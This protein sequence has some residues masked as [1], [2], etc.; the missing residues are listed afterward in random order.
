MSVYTV[1]SILAVFL[2]AAGL[3]AALAMLIST[4]RTEKKADP[5]KLRKIHRAAGYLFFLLLL[6]LSILGGDIFIDSGDSLSTRAVL[7][8]VLALFLLFIVL[9]KI[10][11]VRYFRLFLRNVPGLGMAVLVLAL[12]VFS[13]SAGYFL[14]RAAL[15]D[16]P[17][18]TAPSAPLLQGSPDSGRESFSRHCASCHNADSEEVKLG[19]GLKGLFRRDRLPASGRPATEENVRRQLTAPFRSMPFFGQL[20]AR[21]VADLIAYLKSL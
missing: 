11:L 6:A 4:G 15:K 2:V 10:G 9:L 19:P 17:L 1:K 8:A 13:V 5:A 12:V 14:L 21:E 18:P 3:C 20:Q 7:H 16:N